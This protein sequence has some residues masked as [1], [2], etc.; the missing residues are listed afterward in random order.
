VQLVPFPLKPDLQAQVYDPAVLVQT[1]LLSQLFND[2]SAHSSI[3]EKDELALLFI[4]LF[5]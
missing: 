2:E 5:E 1:A 3:S 4:V